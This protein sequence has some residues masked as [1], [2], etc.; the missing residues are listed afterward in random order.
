MPSREAITKPRS[1]V[2][3]RLS[4]IR[5]DGLM[6][7]VALAGLAIA[8]AIFEPSTLKGSALLSMLPFAGILAIASVGQCLT[9]QGGGMDLS[10]AG[11][12]TLA[13]AVVTGHAAG[14]DDLL[15][16]A[17]VLAFVAV[18]IGGLLNG[19]AIA[20]LKIT[21]I[22]AT[23]AVNALLVGFVQTYTNAIPK[24]ASD[25]L[26]NFALQ[27][28]AGIPNTVWV[29]AIFVIVISLVIGKTVIGR[30]LVAVGANPQTA[31]ASGLRV[32]R[33]VI[34]TYVAAAICFGAAG[35]VLAGY[36]Q[37]PSTSAGNP[38]LFSTI[39]AVVVGGTAFGGGRG[40]IVGTA[41]AA[42]FLS[43]LESF[44]TA[45][46][47]PS[48]VTLLVQ[49]AA[50]AIAATFSNAEAAVRLRRLVRRSLPRLGRQASGHPV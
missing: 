37:T 34:G 13:A 35:I 32:D 21:P 33:Y 29:A 15:F 44:L 23:L 5:R 11:S 46:G 48:S 26:S 45:T 17:I 24:Q 20:K 31:L 49:A 1:E 3:G 22:I 16:S 14:R 38:Y 41:V 27:K 43:Q 2:L 30:R 9:I 28:T 12:M 40:R 18:A 8:C 50:I 7:W 25:N 19:I 10:V 39:T 36:L 4:M 42:V 47:A 6:V